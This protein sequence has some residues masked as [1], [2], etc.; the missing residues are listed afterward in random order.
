MRLLSFFV[1]ETNN[2][3]SDST[4]HVDRIVQDMDLKPYAAIVTISGDGLFH[5][6]VNSLL[7]RPDWNEARKIP[8]GMIAGGNSLNSDSEI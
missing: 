4:G 5:E 7:T 2:A 1:W 8:I 3:D 6:L